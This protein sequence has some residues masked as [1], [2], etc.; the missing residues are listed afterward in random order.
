MHTPTKFYLFCEHLLREDEYYGLLALYLACH[1]CLFAEIFAE[2]N[3]D[4][5]GD[6]DNLVTSATHVKL[7]RN[8]SVVCAHHHVAVVNLNFP[9]TVP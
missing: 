6:I 7:W 8:Y 4:I 3:L 9:P 2:R 5:P 1:E